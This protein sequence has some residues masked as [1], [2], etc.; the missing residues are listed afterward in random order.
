MPKGVSWGASALDF[1]YGSRKFESRSLHWK[2]KTKTSLKGVR[3]LRFLGLCI[4][5]GL[6]R[7]TPSVGVMSLNPG[8]CTWS[9]RPNSC[10]ERGLSGCKMGLKT[11]PLAQALLSLKPAKTQQRFP[12]YEGCYTSV[13]RWILL[14]NPTMWLRKHNW[15]ATESEEEGKFALSRCFLKMQFLN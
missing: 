2:L 14:E 11:V 1:K 10:E 8:A 5:E 9:R 6:E 15:N 4:A 3:I 7:L 13:P 12:S